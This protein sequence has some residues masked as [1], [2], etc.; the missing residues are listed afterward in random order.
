MI[1]THTALLLCSPFLLG[2]CVT[3]APPSPATAAHTEHFAL[4]DLPAEPL[5]PQSIPYPQLNEQTQIDQMGLQIARL[6]RTVEQLQ[7]RVQQLE[8]RSKTRPAAKAPAAPRLD[9]AK[10]KSRYLAGGGSAPSDTDAVTL[11]ETRLYNQALK[12]YQRGNFSAAAAVLRGADGGNGSEAARR[13]MYLL[14]QSQQRMGNCESVIEIG[15][16]YANRFRGSA[17]AP[18]ALY[19]IGQCQYNMQQKDIARNTWRKLMQ[20]Y[21]DSAAAKRAAV[22]LQQR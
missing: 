1:R 6:E 11:N 5:P 20:T 4:P 19:G 14:L 18:E 16:R 7:T 15:G 3:A 13:N 8:R 9:D 2:A 10:L 12:Y 21:P 22:R 17:Q